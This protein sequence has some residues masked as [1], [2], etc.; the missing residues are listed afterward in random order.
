[1]VNKFIDEN[2]IIIVILETIQ[3][4]EVRE[5]LENFVRVLRSISKSIKRDFS[6][7][8]LILYSDDFD[9]DHCIPLKPN[10][11]PNQIISIN[12][13]L[14]ATRMLTLFAN[15]KHP[16]H[17]GFHL[18]HKNGIITHFSQYVIP[19]K[20]PGIKPHGKHGT[21]FLTALLTSFL[22]GVIAVGIVE[23]NSETYLFAKGKIYKI[24]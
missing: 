21:R 20:I 15:K 4:E 11:I 1:M 24:E 13:P 23:S 17:D 22:K 5:T 12:E 10:I 6:G 3:Q 18:V 8:G 2:Q 19:P 16:L 9:L 14:F 7:I